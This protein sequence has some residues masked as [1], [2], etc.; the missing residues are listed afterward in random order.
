MHKSIRALVL[1][2]YDATVSIRGCSPDWRLCPYSLCEGFKQARWRVSAWHLC[3]PAQLCSTLNEENESIYI[4]CVRV[5]QQ[6]DQSTKAI[7]NHLWYSYVDASM[8]EK[9]DTAA[10]IPYICTLGV[11]VPVCVFVCVRACI[12]LWWHKQKHVWPIFHTFK[13]LNLIIKVC[14]LNTHA[15]FAWSVFNLFR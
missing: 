14:L 12:I 8:Q 4:G 3:K 1:R 7:C 2:F 9:R 11:F 10:S 5:K 15:L 6:Y 13:A